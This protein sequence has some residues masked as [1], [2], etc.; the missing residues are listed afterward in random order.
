MSVLG[1]IKDLF[2]ER[3][4]ESIIYVLCKVL[5]KD[6][7]DW[8]VTANKKSTDYRFWIVQLKP[9]LTEASLADAEISIIVHNIMLTV[10]KLS[11]SSPSK[12]L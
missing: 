5:P 12:Y 4:V 8:K 2:I 7:A 1:V 9:P 6:I 11:S 3:G 10:R